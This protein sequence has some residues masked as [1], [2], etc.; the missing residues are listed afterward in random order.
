MELPEGCVRISMRE[1]LG[2]PFKAIVVEDGK[3]VVRE[4]LDEC[5]LALRIDAAIKSAGGCSAWA[6]QIGITKSYAHDL[7]HRRRSPSDRILSA[8]GLE[9]VQQ[10]QLY[11]EVSHG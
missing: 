10:Q 11:R 5:G 4:F 1:A 9:R 6:R 3:H 8:L 7:Q 2:K